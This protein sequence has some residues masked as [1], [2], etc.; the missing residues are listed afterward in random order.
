M[1]AL[2][3]LRS[4]FHPSVVAVEPC[5]VAAVGS[6]SALHRARALWPRTSTRDPEH[7]WGTCLLLLSKGPGSGSLGLLWTNLFIALFLC[8]LTIK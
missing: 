5:G 8:S 6:G 7:C 3:L 1:V 4:C 2:Q